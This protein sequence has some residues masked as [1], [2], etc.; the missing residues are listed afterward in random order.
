Q[1]IT[2]GEK[3]APFDLIIL[4]VK[5]YH[6][7]D[8]IRDIRPYVGDSTAILP[9]LNGMSHMQRLEEAFGREKILA[10]LCQ[11]ETTLNE[12]GA[13]EQY[14]SFH[15]IVFGCLDGSRSDWGNRMGRLCSGV[16]VTSQS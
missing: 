12:R 13:V 15:N 8:A 3:A 4:S 10:G 11:I 1:A 6:L 5:A 14:R 7:E 16:R 2:A 9:L